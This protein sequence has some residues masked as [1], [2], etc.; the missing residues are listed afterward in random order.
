MDY[1]SDFGEI[2]SAPVQYMGQILPDYTSTHSEEPND[3]THVI[4]V[5]GSLPPLKSVRIVFSNA[6]ELQIREFLKFNGIVQIGN[7]MYLK[8]P[9]RPISDIRGKSSYIYYDGMQC[10]VVARSGDEVSMRT[11]A[12]SEILWNESELSLIR[13]RA[14]DIRAMIDW[15]D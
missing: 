15:P 10:H 12:W 3:L 5:F 2:C 8:L 13:G 9:T 4:Y 1:W 7:K 11:C 6:S 14:V